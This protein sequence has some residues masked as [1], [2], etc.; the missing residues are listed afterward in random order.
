MGDGLAATLF[1]QFADFRAGGWEHGEAE[2]QQGRH[3]RRGRVVT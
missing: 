2:R 3:G 1:D